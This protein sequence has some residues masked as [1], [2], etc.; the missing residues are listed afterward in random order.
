MLH[1]RL[2]TNKEVLYRYRNQ[3]ADNLLANVIDLNHYE[4][5][6]AEDPNYTK[7]NQYGQKVSVKDLVASNRQ[8]IKNAKHN[9]VFIDEL[10]A[11][12]AAGT[13]AKYYSDEVTNKVPV[14]LVIPRKTK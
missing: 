3:F 5:L 10:I 1:D 9:L 6:M 13:L 4:T 8:G 12:E 14:E 7:I 11:A 2:L